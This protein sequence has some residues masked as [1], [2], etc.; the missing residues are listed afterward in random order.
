MWLRI[1]I[2]YDIPADVQQKGQYQLDAF[3]EENHN[4]ASDHDD[5]LNV[6]S[7]ELMAEIA[8]CVNAGRRCA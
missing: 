1:T 7:E 5:F 2:A 4:P 6:N 3:D 8:G